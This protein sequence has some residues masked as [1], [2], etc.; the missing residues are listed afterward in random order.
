MCFGVKFFIV[1]V[2]LNLALWFVC[3]NMHGVFGFSSTDLF[4]MY[5][6]L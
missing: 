6:D 5:V 4:S 3:V 1:Q 2:G